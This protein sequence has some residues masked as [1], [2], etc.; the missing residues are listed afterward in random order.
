MKSFVDLT[1]IN[2]E[3][4]GLSARKLVPRF[5]IYLGLGGFRIYT[6][7]CKYIKL[8]ITAPAFSIGGLSI[9]GLLCQLFLVSSDGYWC[10]GKHHTVKAIG[11]QAPRSLYPGVSASVLQIGPEAEWTPEPVWTNWR[12]ETSRSCW[13][14]NRG[15]PVCSL[16][17]FDSVKCNINWQ[18]IPFLSIFLP[19]WLLRGTWRSSFVK[20]SLP[21]A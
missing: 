21:L 9:R 2:G 10:R 5:T 15:R 8:S 16:Q 6:Q 12:R 7:I 4:N 11:G 20:L 19:I 17:L 1:H 18:T 14:S 13:E 3:A